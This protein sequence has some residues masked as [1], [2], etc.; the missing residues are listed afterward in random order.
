MLRGGGGEKRKRGRR[1]KKGGGRGGGQDSLQQQL[2]HTAPSLSL[3]LYLLP[4]SKGQSSN[5]SSTRQ[6]LDFHTASVSEVDR[7]I[8]R[9]SYLRINHLQ[10]PPPRTHSQRYPGK[11]VTIAAACL[12]ATPTAAEAAGVERP[13]TRRTVHRPPPPTDPPTPNP[14][15]QPDPT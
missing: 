3:S 15:S 9:L 11:K 13:L 5:S 10:F 2:L 12:P 14:T 6:A 1:G 8:D 4:T 7:H